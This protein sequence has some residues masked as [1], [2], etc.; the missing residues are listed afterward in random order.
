MYGNPQSYRPQ[1]MAGLA[2]QFPP[3]VTATGKPGELYIEGVGTRKFADMR[4]DSIYDRV[5]IAAAN[6]IGTEYVWFRDIPGKNLLDTNMRDASKLPQGQQAV[7]YR[8]NF[9]LRDDT[10]PEDKTEILSTGYGAFILD[11]NNVV[12][13]GPMPLFPQTY[14]AHGSI[15]TTLNATTKGVVTSGVPSAGAIPKLMVPIYLAEGRTFRFILHFY[16]ACN[17]PSAAATYAWVILDC[18]RSRPLV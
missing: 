14:G 9:V 10:P 5:N 7:V 2:Q 13:E 8:I 1:F 11:D 12:K 16:E 6:P 17:L 3:G 18:L 4:E 15:S